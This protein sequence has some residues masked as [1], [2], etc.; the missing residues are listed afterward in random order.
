MPNGRLN[1]GIGEGAAT[2]WNPQQAVQNFNNIIQTRQAKQAAEQAELAKEL[3]SVKMDGLRND[4]DRQSFLTK[5]QDLKNQAIIAQQQRDP[6][7]KAMAKAQIQQ[8]LL[9]LQDY[10]GRSKQAGQR[11]NSILSSLSDPMKRHN[12]TDDSVT[13]AIGNTKLA[14]DDPNY[15]P[16]Y[17]FLNRQVDHNKINDEFT[18]AN[19]LALTQSQWSNPIESTDK[20]GNKNGVVIYNQRQLTPEQLLANHA[21][22]YDTDD[23]IKQSLEQRYPDVKGANANETKMLR[24]RQN[25][26]DRGDLVQDANGALQTAIVEKSRPTFKPDRA[27]DLYYE[28]RDY[29]QANPLT[30]P[31]ANDPT[32]FQDLSERM[33]QGIE[34]KKNNGS[35][36]EFNNQLANNP[37]YLHGL[38]INKDN[39][40]AVVLTVPAKYHQVKNPNT[41]E[42]QP[43]YVRAVETPSY[44]VTLDS[45]DPTQ[46]HAGFARVYRDITG[47]AT[48]APSKAMTQGGKGKVAGGLTNPNQRPTQTA[49]SGKGKTATMQQ[50]NSLVG[51]KEYAGYTA[52]ELADYYKSLGYTIK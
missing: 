27:P 48:A 43:E 31:K 50:I 44:K 5:Y 51:K 47:D 18:K 36:E 16:D 23:D 41:D 17:T 21:H 12:Y 3:A 38:T 34:T 14:L 25:A 52:K 22:M 9:G 42:G 35:G 7:K 2:V 49:P 24:I 40:K 33:R 13:Q 10:V 28:H 39:P 8:G 20:Q 26:L 37:D 6:M 46:W 15:K 1:I 45:T 32:Y 19:K 4:A 11:D 30:Q 29:A